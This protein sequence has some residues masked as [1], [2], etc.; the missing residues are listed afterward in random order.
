MTRISLLAFAALA[1]LLA[2]CASLPQAPA[3][4][5]AFFANLTA[6]CGQ[7]FPGRLVR[8]T[9]PMPISPVSRCR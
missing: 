6:L 2:S 1:P 7:S 9:P 4:Q 3:P 8:P 5:D